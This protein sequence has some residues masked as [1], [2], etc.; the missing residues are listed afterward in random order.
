[1]KDNKQAVINVKGHHFRADGIILE[2]HFQPD[3]T[4]CDSQQ[5]INFNELEQII[6]K[7]PVLAALWNKKIQG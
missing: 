3:K 1:M 4:V 2:T 7:L 5:T 6:S